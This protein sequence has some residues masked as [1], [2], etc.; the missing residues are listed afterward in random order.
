MPAPAFY[1][2]GTGE[3]ALEACPYCVK[4]VGD[5]SLK[6]LFG[7]TGFEDGEYDEELP[8]YYFVAPPSDNHADR[9]AAAVSH[10]FEIFHPR[11]TV[12]NVSQFQYASLVHWATATA[13]KL[14]DINKQDNLLKQCAYEFKT[15]KLK[16]QY[17]ESEFKEQEKVF[18]KLQ[19]DLEKAEGVLKDTTDKLNLHE[20]YKNHN[21]DSLFALFEKLCKTCKEK[22]KEISELKG[23]LRGINDYRGHLEQ[24]NHA[25]EYGTWL[26]S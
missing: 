8:P 12:T 6:K 19:Q 20:L 18:Q 2:S 13:A 16:L 14:H 15:L 23:L 10:I 21:N 1:P 22:D 26:E 7:V 25:L 9:G 5:D 11:N 3:P 4:T 24:T 17:S